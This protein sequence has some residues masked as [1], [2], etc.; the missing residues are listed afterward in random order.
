MINKK[1]RVLF[2]CIH[3]SARSQIAE[4]FFNQLCGD[5]FEALSAG[6]E[7]GKLNPLTVEV[8]KEV[9]IDI[10]GKQTQA[11]FDLAKRG[12]LF[13]YVVTVCDEAAERC[14]IFPGAS[15]RVAWS[16][17]D[18]SRFEGTWEERL[19]RTRDVR[20]EIKRRIEEW[21]ST[22]CQGELLS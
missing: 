8:M 7:P 21:C 10:S 13:S 9:G 12:E 22:V 17:P 4:A 16:F 20:D 5:E 11:A 14:P 19:Q 18:P 15:E 3:N 2:L 6:V 1:K